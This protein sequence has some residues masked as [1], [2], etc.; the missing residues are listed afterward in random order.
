MSTEITRF[1]HDV[2]ASAAMQEEIKAFCGDLDKASSIACIS[3][4]LFSMVEHSI[5][6]IGAFLPIRKFDDSKSKAKER[7]PLA[8]AL[9]ISP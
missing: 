4:C 3:R 8:S 7:T 9:L 2:K 6:L 5:K 1:N